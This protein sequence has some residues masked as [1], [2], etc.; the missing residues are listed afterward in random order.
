MTDR[1]PRHTIEKNLHPAY[2]MLT[3]PQPGDLEAHTVY[4]VYTHDGGFNP[5]F[6]GEFYT[7]EAA[8]ARIA[9]LTGA[10]Q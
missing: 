5:L 7:L 9:V 6:E 2:H 1:Q 4:H 10:A 3:N 8:Q